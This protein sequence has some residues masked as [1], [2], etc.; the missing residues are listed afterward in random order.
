[1]TLNTIR[2]RI[3]RKR[4]HKR[5]V[6]EI[7]AA[8]FVILIMF[9]AFGVFTVM[10]NSYVSYTKQANTVNSQDA[11]NRATSLS[12]SSFQFGS[13]NAPVNAYGTSCGTSAT[14]NTDGNKLVYASGMWFSFFVCDVTGTYDLAFTSSYDGITWGAVTIPGSSLSGLGSGSAMSLYLAGSTLYVAVSNVGSAAFV[15]ATGTLAAG[16]TVSAPLG[17]F[18]QTT[19]SPYSVSTGSGSANKASGPISIELDKTGNEWVALT[20]GTKIQVF[21]HPAASAPNSGW[22]ANIAASA[23]GTLSANAVP[24]ILSPP[25]GLTSTGAVLVYETGSATVASTGQISMIAT[26]TVSSS[27]WSTVI[28]LGGDGL[29]DYSLTSS[30][31]SMV[32]YVLCVAGLAS[33]GLGAKTGTLDFWNFQFTTS[34]AAGIISHQT[35]LETTTASWQAA[36]TASSSTLVLFDNPSGTSVQSYVSNNL[37][38]TWTNST[39]EATGESAIDGLSPA[40]GVSA[41]TWTNSGGLVRFLSL[42]YLTVINNSAF[43]VELVSL[44]ISNPATNGLVA[45]YLKNSSGLFDYWVGAGE[46]IAT[47][48]YFAYSSSTSYLVTIGTST[49]V[50]AANTFSSIA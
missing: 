17:T 8:L 26:T 45:I 46:S 18:T 22:S 50:M 38:S 21:E 23:L 2:N 27:G 25:S 12:L 24:I 15:Y 4:N 35:Q 33:S 11:Q 28:P 32:G 9:V 30:S 16:G 37:G 41:V 6:A 39:V 31:A 14:L 48:T 7:V 40:F 34:L 44:F 19:G 3:K 1:M 5:G 43:P 29:S 13:N 36:L 47:P 42:S 49:G 20:T 10:F